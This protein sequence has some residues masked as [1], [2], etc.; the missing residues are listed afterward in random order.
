MLKTQA[1]S[2][3]PKILDLNQILE[4]QQIKSQNKYRFRFQNNKK[5]NA[6]TYNS[7]KLLQPKKSDSPDWNQ[8]FMSAVGKN[9]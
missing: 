6:V 9:I 7:L 4:E 8:S 2:F 5:V 1:L 3:K